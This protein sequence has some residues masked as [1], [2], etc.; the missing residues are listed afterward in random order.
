VQPPGPSA[1]VV[2][3][4]VQSFIK[5][6]NSAVE[7]IQ[8]QLATKP[9][10]KATSASEFATGALFGDIELTSL[11]DNMRASMYEPLKGLE[12]GMSSPF[13]LGIATG[14][15]TGSGTSS[16]ASIEGLLTLN[17]SKLSE[18]VKTN[19]AGVEKMLTQWSKSLQGTINAVSEAGGGLETRIN[20]DT[21]QITQLSSRIASMNEVLADREKALQQTYA[22]L[23]A[24]IAQNTAQGAE[25]A[26]QAESLSTL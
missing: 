25:L 18:A 5:L 24:V 3:A 20:G 22:Q 15:S 26:K 4:Q 14:G 6:Y 11:L 9:L 17:A 10:A 1:S 19:P 2:E 21:A 16:Q 7:A 8:K 23:E 13:D 12:A